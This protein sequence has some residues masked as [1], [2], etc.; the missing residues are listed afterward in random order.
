MTD[1]GSDLL[2]VAAHELKSP[3]GAVR[4][5][6]DLIEQMGPLNEGQQKF[7]NRA[8][9]I[10]EHME[11]L[12]AELLEISRLDGG[13][14]FELASCN[15]GDIVRQLV[16][17]Q[18]TSAEARNITLHVEIAPN[19]PDVPCDQRFLPQAVSNLLSNAIKY[20][21]DGGEIWVRVAVEGD[22]VRLSV[23][24]TGIGI[25][26]EDQQ[27]VFEPFFRARETAALRIEG[28][29]LG[30]AITHAVVQQHGGRISVVSEPDKGST[31]TITLPK[32]G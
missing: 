24:D 11:H 21:R 27:R 16:D 28:S 2:R 8:L 7:A 26:T 22:E 10:L 12:I 23:R 6:I 15:L 14:Q 5:C 25:S 17:L 19:L 18:S 13:V 31:F 4:G 1:L 32:S 30:L 29:G 9:T 3:I 20:N